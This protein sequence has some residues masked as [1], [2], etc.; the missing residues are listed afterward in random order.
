M[1]A[2]IK[3][4]MREC[5]EGSLK[6]NMDFPEVVRR[7]SAIGCEQYHAD[8]R[9]KEKT[10]YMPDGESYVNPLEITCERI[11]SV[12]SPDQVVAALRA[13]QSKQITYPQFLAWIV[14]AG[15]VGYVV[16]LKGKRAIYMGRSGDS[17]VE[18]FPQ[19]AN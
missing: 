19:S 4:V 10:Y 9:R 13:I 16:S 3:S 6:G 2:N 8:L 18:Q 14:D 7:L 1:D 17:Y 12:F 15:C 11:A 5:S